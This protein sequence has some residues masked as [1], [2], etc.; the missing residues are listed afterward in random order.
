MIEIGISSRFSYPF[1]KKLLRR[2]VKKFLQEKG[3][4]EV[5]LS[6]AMVGERKMR[7]LNQDFRDKNIVSDVLAFPQNER[8]VE[9][10]ALLLGD[11]VVCYPRAQKEAIV[12]QETIDE[13]IWDFVEHGLERLVEG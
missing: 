8:A 9:G 7:Q 3:V 1:D 6:I 2:R 10:G 4:G 11:I 5:E 13:A 12:L